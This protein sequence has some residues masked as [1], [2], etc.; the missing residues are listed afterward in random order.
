MLGTILKR[1][2]VWSLPLAASYIC[3]LYFFGPSGKRSLALAALVF[4]LLA[5]MFEAIKIHKASQGQHEGKPNA[6][7]TEVIWCWSGIAICLVVFFTT[8]PEFHGGAIGFLIATGAFGR[9]LF[10]P[11]R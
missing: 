5:V 9:R 11:T 2:L 4:P 3:L 8:W 6:R 10:V 1:T 7:T